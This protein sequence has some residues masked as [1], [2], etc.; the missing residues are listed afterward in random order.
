MRRR[1]PLPKFLRSGEAAF[2]WLKNNKDRTVRAEFQSKIRD[3]GKDYDDEESAI[4]H[5]LDLC[6]SYCDFANS[7]FEFKDGIVLY[8]AL[9]LPSGVDVVWDK[10]GLYWSGHFGHADCYGVPDMDSIHEIMVVEAI[11]SPDDVDWEN[12]LVAFFMNDEE[13]EVRLKPNVKISVIG[14]T[15]VVTGKGPKKQ[16]FNPPLQANSGPEPV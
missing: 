1:N 9:C 4:N 12:G 6:F 5:A 7:A 14:L 8:R 15:K 11:V 16:K 3:I 2:E 13:W 10:L